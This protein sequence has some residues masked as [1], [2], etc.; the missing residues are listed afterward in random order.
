MLILLFMSIG[1]GKYLSNKLQLDNVV[2]QVPALA[3]KEM[4]MYLHKK[5][6]ALAPQLSQALSEM[7]K[8]G[9][10][11]GLVNKHLTVLLEKN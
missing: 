9:S 1:G 4:F 5:H 10:Y 11:Q 8:D 2:L 7:K 6:A 3:K